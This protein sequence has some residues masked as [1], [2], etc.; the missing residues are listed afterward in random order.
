MNRVRLI[1]WVFWWVICAVAL[2]A[3]PPAI[4]GVEAVGVTV[5]DLDRSV[6]FYTR[7]LH[8]QKE[9][10][11]ELSGSAVEHLKGVFG[12]RMRIAR[13]RLGDEV[14]ELTEYLAPQGRQFPLDSKSN[15]LWFQHVAIVVSDMDEA[16][17]WLRG[18]HVQHVSS[19]P[20]TLPSWNAQAGGI[21]AFY[22][23]DPDGHVLE[24]IHFPTGKGNPRWQQHG[25]QLFLGIDHTAIAVSNTDTSLA[26][27]RD[28]L[29]MHVAG[30]SENYGEEQ[31]HLNNVFGARL[32]ITSLHAAQG[33]G[34]ELLEYLSPRTGRKIPEDAHAN[35]LAHWETLVEDDD[36][37]GAW[38]NLTNSHAKLISSGIE[39]L[40]N[41]EEFLFSDPD[42]HVIAAMKL[43]GLEAANGQ[44]R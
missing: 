32:R 8:F 2:L 17:Q 37:V 12:V 18:H 42:G 38:A 19:G 43:N 9:T 5:S 39:K 40:E 24:I 16:Y 22:F 28:Q 4:K 31:E 21:Q 34:I 1:E 25:A 11:A 33:P 6:E 30:T 7:V 13:L 3:Q 44:G 29:G 14:L 20:Q 36:L 26:F 35:D 23:R 41:R 10:Q 27:Y 15:D